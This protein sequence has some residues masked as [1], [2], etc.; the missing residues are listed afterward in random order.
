[1]KVSQLNRSGLMLVM[2]A[3]GGLAQAQLTTEAGFVKGGPPV[4]QFGWEL[5]DLQGSGSLAFS[6]DLIGALSVAGIT[7]SIT[8]P[9]TGTVAADAITIAAPILTINR[10]FDA[11]ALRSEG[12]IANY[13]LNKVGTLG[14]AAMLAPAA[15]FATS[16]GSLSVSAISV[17]LASK[18][19]FARVSGGNGLADQRVRVWNYTSIEGDTTQQLNNGTMV[20][21]NTL[22]GLTITSEAFDM[23][24]QGL[25][26]KAGGIAA[27]KSIS[28]YGVMSSTLSFTVLPEPS[29]YLMMGLGLVGLALAAKR[30]KAA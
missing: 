4:G 22:T 14:G 23:F 2:L 6:A 13:T 16:G 10:H 26:L 28:D 20:F 19:I 7:T 18:S 27:M 8:A 30:R 15:N 25:G 11:T 21:N 5:S 3:A 1:M 9:A 24:A 12:G 29:T 17:D